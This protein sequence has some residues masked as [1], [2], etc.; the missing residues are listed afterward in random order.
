MHRYSNQPFATEFQAFLGPH[1]TP[2]LVGI[3]C[4]PVPPRVT[5]CYLVRE[6]QQQQQ[7]QGSVSGGREVVL[8]YRVW[9]SCVSVQ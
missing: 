7:Q 3:Q 2:T 8:T 5:Y 6:L 9:D 1:Y 4:R